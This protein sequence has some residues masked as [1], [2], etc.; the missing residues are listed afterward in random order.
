MVYIGLKGGGSLTIKTNRFFS[1]YLIRNVLPISE[2][3]IR[4]GL[5]IENYIIINVSII[6]ET[7]YHLIISGTTIKASVSYFRIITLKETI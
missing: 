6:A 7:A 5:I 4:S 1:R 2:K 3:L